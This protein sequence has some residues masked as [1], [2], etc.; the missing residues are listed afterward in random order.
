MF[1]IDA[2]ITRPDW[3]DGGRVVSSDDPRNPLGH[4]WLGLAQSGTATSYGI[5]ST[6]EAQSIGRSTSRG[7]IRMRPEDVET[8]FRFCPI[9]T[10]VSICP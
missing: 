1:R 8:V 7:C 10:P 4:R 9:G 2:K 6:S 5:H 3:Y